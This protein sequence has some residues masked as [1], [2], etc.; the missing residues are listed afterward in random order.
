MQTSRL[1]VAMVSL[2]F[3]REGGSE[4]RTGHLVDRL[5]HD[6]HEVHLV[7]GRIG[8]RWD[9]R[10]I[11]RPVWTPEH[12][13]WLEVA[14]F[15]R[16]A[17]AM[18]RAGGYDIVHNQIR[19]FVPGAVTVGGGSH[20]YY[21]NQ[22]LARESG[23]MRA[24]VR[25]AMP[26]HRVL[27]ALERRGFRPERCP[28]VIANSELNRQSILRYY[29]MAPERVVVAYN[30]VDST[31]FSPALRA[32]H[33]EATRRILGLGPQDVGVLLVGQGFA[34]KGLGVLLQALALVREPKW[35]LIV[36]GRGKAGAWSA[37]A[38]RLG[39]AGRVEFVGHVAAPEAYYAAADIFALPTFFDPFANATLEA[40]AVGLPIITSAQN[41]VAEILH[42]GVDG[43]VVDR[44]GDVHGL[45]AALTTL[46]DAGTRAALGEHARE[47]ALQFTWDGPLERTLGVYREMVQA[48]Q[49]Q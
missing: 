6:G 49:R 45:A 29:P 20:R 1:R 11:Q 7:G 42:P 9:P 37:R 25:R 33:R 34:R 8:G 2:D 38:A 13:H 4:G 14:L 40:M 17:E 32:L 23:H 27:L 3:H 46:A 48:V 24:A 39:L 35:R 28:Y 44:P 15:S 26:L 30:G 19:P 36:V 31:R 21:L 43:L 16:R 10:I 12:P 18:V 22:V 5:V 41:G 47:T